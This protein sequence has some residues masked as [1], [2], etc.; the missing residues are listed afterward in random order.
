MHEAD[1]A[2]ATD[3]CEG[4]GPCGVHGKSKLLLDL[5]PVEIVVAAGVDDGVR[6]NG[7]DEARETVW[8]AQVGLGRGGLDQRDA[9]LGCGAG[10]Q[11]LRNLPVPA[12]GRDPQ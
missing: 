10:C 11:G 1:I 8:I 3:A 9:G 2:F 7:I 4:A 12:D 6:S 5:R